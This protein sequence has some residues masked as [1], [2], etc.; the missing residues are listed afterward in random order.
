[1]I[2]TVIWVRDAFLKMIFGGDMKRKTSSQNSSEKIFSK[3]KKVKFR[4]IHGI[5]KEDNPI[6]LQEACSQFGIFGNVHP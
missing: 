5:R 6:W 3:I 4:K 2:R 1:M